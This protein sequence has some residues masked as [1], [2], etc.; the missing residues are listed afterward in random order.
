MLEMTPRERVMT[1]LDH[2]E[3]DRVPLDI[4]GGQSTS[5][6]AEAYENLLRH[7]DRPP[8]YGC[9]DILPFLW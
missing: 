4:G 9:Q 3:P 6:V 7:C 8:A 1:A 2:K 5:L